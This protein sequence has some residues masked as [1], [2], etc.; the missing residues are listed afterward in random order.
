MFGR[1][2]RL[3]DWLVRRTP[4]PMRGLLQIKMFSLGIARYYL[5]L[6]GITWYCWIVLVDDPPLRSEAGADWLAPHFP[7]LQSPHRFGQ[8]FTFQCIPQYEPDI[9]FYCSGC[10]LIALCDSVTWLH[11]S[12][13]DYQIALSWVLRC[14]LD[15]FELCIAIHIRL[16]DMSQSQPWRRLCQGLPWCGDP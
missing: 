15:C 14:T 9:A 7:Q 12:A 11:C 13:L 16:A 3:T 4:S 10:G 8:S 6:L 2:G 1:C 5:V